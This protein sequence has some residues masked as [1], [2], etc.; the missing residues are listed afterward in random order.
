MPRSTLDTFVYATILVAPLATALGYI[1]LTPPEVLVVAGPPTDCPEPVAVAIADAEVSPAPEPEPEPVVEPVAAAPTSLAGAGVLLFERRL[2]LATR[3]D[4]AWSKGQ[5]RVHPNES[6]ITVSK[7]AD[8]AKLPAALAALTGARFMVYAA[9][10]SACTTFA[11]DASIYARVD[12]DFYYEEEQA[13]AL[14]QVRRDVW[15]DHAEL[16]LARTVGPSRCTG[17][18]ARRADLPA[19]AVFGARD[20]DEAATD[21]L[22]QQIAAIIKDE[23][24]VLGL[25]ADYTLWYRDLPEEARDDRAAWPD[26]YRDSLEVRRWDEIGGARTY[27]TVDVGSPGEACSDEF[28]GHVSLVLAPAADP[29]PGHAWDVVETDGFWRPQALMDLDRDGRLEAVTA[30]GT[31]LTTAGSDAALEQSYE[32]PWWGCPC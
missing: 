17:L 22:E 28:Y 9:D 7:A 2:V 27:Y 19:P 18:W 6:G 21:A 24:K 31:T 12:G 25:R 26:F 1:A 16:L 10:G 13:G 15:Q 3:P 32:I 5:L 4:L 29:R 30:G 14:T 23:P 20:L 11:G 8:P